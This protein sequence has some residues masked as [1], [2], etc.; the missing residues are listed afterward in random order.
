M[1]IVRPMKS[2]TELKAEAFDRFIESAQGAS[3]LSTCP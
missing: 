2:E 3:E 1:A